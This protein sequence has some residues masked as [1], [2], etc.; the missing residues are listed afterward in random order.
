MLNLYGWS[1]ALSQDFAPFA[2]LDLKPARVVLQQRGSYGLISEVGEINGHLAGKLQ[3]TAG[4]GGLPAVGDWVAV[5]QHLG[6]DLAIIH[7]VLARRSAFVRKVAGTVEAPQ[8][9]AANIDL[10]FL[11][12][13]MGP[14]FNLR[15]LERYLVAAWDSGATPVIL[16][17]KADTCD[18]PQ[19]PL[20]AVRA[21][22][23]D[24]EVLSVSSVTGEGL[25]AVLDR[26]TCGLT[27]VLIG[28]SGVGKST[29]ANA[30]I[31][32][33]RQATQAVRQ[34]DDRGRHTTT[35]RELL[36]VPGGGMIMDTPGIRELAMW[37]AAD[38]VSATF[39]DVERLTADCRFRDC[40][41]GAE[42][43]CAVQAALV[44]GALSAERWRGFDKL[45]RE[46]Q[47]Q[48]RKEDPLA[49]MQVRKR[50]A[51]ISKAQRR[52]RHERDD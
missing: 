20:A 15:R 38:G 32:E 5:S 22:A 37:D 3:H 45:R 7:H 47:Y 35:Q 16:L 49:R 50:W 8:V 29:L 52:I 42:P 11:V 28:M 34:G 21:I 30:L 39:D 25:E 18:D 41:H 23:G 2:A 19:A 6:E 24:V 51:Q 13:A 31:G 9:I 36:L 17:T 33:D 12:S 40:N 1:D 44:N 27:A 10:A 26:L 14:D 43:G 46:T 4:P 48:E